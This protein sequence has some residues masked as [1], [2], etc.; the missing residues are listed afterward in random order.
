MKVSTL[1]EILAVFQKI[2]VVQVEGV[3]STLLEILAVSG[4]VKGVFAIH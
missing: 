4:F 3:V 2:G 1:L